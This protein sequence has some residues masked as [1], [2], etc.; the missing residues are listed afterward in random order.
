MSR[1]TS[2]MQN[3]QFPNSCIT[4]QD[5]IHIVILRFLIKN[6]AVQIGKFKRRLKG[7]KDAIKTTAY[8]F[9]I[10]GP[11]NL[12]ASDRGIPTTL[13]YDQSDIKEFQYINWFHNHQ[14]TCARPMEMS[15]HV[16]KQN[17]IPN[18]K[19]RSNAGT[20]LVLSFPQFYQ[21]PQII[22]GLS[23][24]DKSPSLMSRKKQSR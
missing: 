4:F 2:Q 21:E 6:I 23:S 1:T 9:S 17:E 22:S 5:K 20:G 3:T 8:G 7:G 12:F 14:F 10:Q 13:R 24:A 11:C 16:I 19:T 15:T 18:W